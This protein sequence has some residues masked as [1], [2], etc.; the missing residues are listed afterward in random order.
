MPT[1][2]SRSQRVASQ[3]S[4]QSSQKMTM[5]LE[6]CTEGKSFWIR[7]VSFPDIPSVPIHGTGLLLRT[8]TNVLIAKVRKAQESLGL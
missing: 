6:L 1:T 4:K 8:L 5:M 3:N 7:T 2:I